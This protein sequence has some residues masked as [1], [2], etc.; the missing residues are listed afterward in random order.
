MWVWG[1]A[2]VPEQRIALN[3]FLSSGLVALFA[4]F[5]LAHARIADSQLLKSAGFAN[6]AAT[7]PVLGV[8]AAD[9]NND[10]LAP[11]PSSLALL[12]AG[13]GIIAAVR[14]RGRWFR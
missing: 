9:E 3:T 12:A 6:S 10:S 5:P 11:E 1:P 7:A 13:L 2:W 4:F 14:G 8:A